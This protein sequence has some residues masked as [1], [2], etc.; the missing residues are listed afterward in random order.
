M[1][2]SLQNDWDPGLYHRFRGL[3]LRPAIDLLRSVGPLPEG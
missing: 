2:A 1:S 3:R